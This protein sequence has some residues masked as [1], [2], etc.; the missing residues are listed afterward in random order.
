MKMQMI[1]NAHNRNGEIVDAILELGHD[2]GKHILLPVAMLPED[3]SEA[4]LR[5]V[6][7]RALGR[8]RSGPTGI[9]SARSIWEAFETEA[10]ETLGDRPT[11]A[12]LG[13]AVGRA[14]AWEGRA[15][16]GVALNRRDLTADLRAV[17]ERI[18]ELLD[19]VAHG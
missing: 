19:E 5:E 2:L 10:G 4:E 8:T 1:D 16:A 9:R 3:A 11:F 6:A 15:T 17:G 14:L 13:K 12:R 7:L 18:R